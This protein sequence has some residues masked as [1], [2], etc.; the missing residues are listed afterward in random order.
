MRN[1]NTAILAASSALVLSCGEGQKLKEPALQ[2]VCD[3]VQDNVAA[4]YWAYPDEGARR[5][6][7]EKQSCET[8]PPAEQEKLLQDTRT[9]LQLAGARALPH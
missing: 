9:A 1:L 7:E 3:Q 6:A 4:L 2:S 5:G 8:L